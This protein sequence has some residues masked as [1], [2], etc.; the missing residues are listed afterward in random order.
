[1]SHD[2]RLSWELVQFKQDK[3]NLVFEA[4]GNEK[5]HL[6]EISTNIQLFCQA[7]YDLQLLITPLASFC[8]HGIK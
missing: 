8:H 2:L 5:K 6:I 7:C 1:M 4:K 3:F